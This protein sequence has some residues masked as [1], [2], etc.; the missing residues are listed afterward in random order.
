[1]KDEKSAK[2]KLVCIAA[3]AAVFI[4]DLF[5]PYATLVN[6]IMTYCG[7]TGGI[8]FAVLTIR[9]IMKM[10]SEKKAA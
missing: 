6:I 2:Y 3:G 1:I 8:V 7:Y 5:I 9:W 4:V 10:S